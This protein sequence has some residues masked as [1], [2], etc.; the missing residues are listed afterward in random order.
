MPGITEVDAL[1]GQAYDCIL[2]PEGWGELLESCARLVGG[3]S[4]VVYVKP[5]AS[6]VGSLL[7]SRDFDRSYNLAS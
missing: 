6:A 5:R 3:E 4:G 2:E 1:I 7:T